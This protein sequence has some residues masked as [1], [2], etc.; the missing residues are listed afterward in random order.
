MPKGPYLRL[1]GLL[2]LAVTD[3]GSS[4]VFTLHGNFAFEQ[5]PL[6][7]PNP[8]DTTPAPKAIRIAASDVSAHVLNTDL[9]AGQGGFVLSSAGIAGSLRVTVAVGDPGVPTLGGDVILQI[10]TTGAA[11]N[12][13]IQVGNTNI[14]IKF[15]AS[16][17]HVV[18]F[19]I[20]NATISLPP[21][22]EL[23]GDF[24][25]QT[26]GDMTLYGARTV[27]IFL[28]SMPSGETLRDS[29]GNLN[30]NAVGLLITHASVGLVKWATTPGSTAR[31][32]VYAY[33]EASL[34]GL[35]GLTISGA[36]TV[37]LNNS[38][39]ALD[40]SIILPTV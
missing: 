16:E 24:T 9:T 30:P 34:V 7:D 3:G 22:F 28:G 32:A 13:S 39:Q 8:A 17:G 36:I 18:R 14:A 1:E 40:K 31:Y 2:D 23:T 5:I 21:F 33:G 25:I 38:G 19:A 35:D 20:L 10:N 27:E 11:V 26:D 15:S 29:A 6:I 37:R 4:S 12:Q